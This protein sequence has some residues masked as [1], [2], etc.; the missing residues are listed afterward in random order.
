MVAGTLMQT[1]A[2]VGMHILSK[3]LSDRYLRAANDKIF[4]PLGLR[5]RLCKMP[6]LRALVDHPDVGISQPSKLKQFGQT[7]GDVALRLPIPIPFV[8]KGIRFLMDKG[9]AID[10]RL[11]DPL[12]RRLMV[13]DGY[14][15]PV[16][17]G[18]AIPPPAKPDGVLDKMNGFV[19][20]RR[21]G[22]VDK[23]ARD[24]AVRREIL[25]GMPITREGGMNRRDYKTAR[26]AARGRTRRLKN[27]VADDARREHNNNERLVW[28][29]IIN[30]ADGKF[31]TRCFSRNWFLTRINVREQTQR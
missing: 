21:S 31:T 30:E 1:G 27:R 12:A 8:K 29:V 9:P 17:Y 5:A 22:K 7:A 6:A 18:Y 11:T 24:A 28:L 3:T 4:A 19:V 16:A 23:K 25:A 10:P 20:G 26:R 15:L 14:I 13:L 2:Q